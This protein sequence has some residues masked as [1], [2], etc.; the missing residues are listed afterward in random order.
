MPS[1]DDK[2]TGKATSRDDKGTGKATSFD[3]DAMGMDTDDDDTGG[4]WASGSKGKGD[5]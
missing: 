2:V 5:S 3:D 4:Q 1:R